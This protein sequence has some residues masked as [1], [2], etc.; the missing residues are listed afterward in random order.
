MFISKKISVDFTETGYTAITDE[1]WLSVVL[2]QIFVNSLKYTQER[3]TVSIYICL[4]YTS[5]SISLRSRMEWV[6]SSA[7]PM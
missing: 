4:L 2:G 1:K 5:C 3:G 7:R 6:I